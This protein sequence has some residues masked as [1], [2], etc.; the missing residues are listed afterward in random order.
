[1]AVIKKL[2]SLLEEALKGETVELVSALRFIAVVEERLYVP[3]S[4]AW[5][6]LMEDALVLRAHEENLIISSMESSDLLA[7]NEDLRS[8]IERY[9]AHDLGFDLNFMNIRT[10]IGNSYRTGVLRLQQTHQ[11]EVRA[12]DSYALSLR[13]LL[14]VMLPESS[15][16]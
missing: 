12:A 3:P 11:R 7:R 8:L 2:E 15:L 10:Q 9:N 5:K 13:D 16:P 1:V 4:K 6:F 14:H